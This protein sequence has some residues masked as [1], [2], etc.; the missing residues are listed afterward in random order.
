MTEGCLDPRWG[1]IPLGHHDHA[2]LSDE[3]D[4]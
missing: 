1:L 2:C 4:T 3:C